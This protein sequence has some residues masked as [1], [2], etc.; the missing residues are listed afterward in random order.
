MLKS[1]CRIDDLAHETAERL[2]RAIGINLVIAWR[3]M[4]MTLMSR[5]SPELLA[6]LLFSDVELRTLTAYA[7]KRIET[8]IITR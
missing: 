5:E 3:I 2:R 7:K 1:G 8:A 4:L 6:D